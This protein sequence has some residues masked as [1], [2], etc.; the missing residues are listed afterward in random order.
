MSRDYCNAFN[1]QYY[2]L[3]THATKH[4]RRWWR[5]VAAVPAA[6]LVSGCLLALIGDFGLVQWVLNGVERRA[7]AGQS[8]RPDQWGLQVLYLTLRLGGRVVRPQAAEL[9]AYYCAGGGDT[10]RFDA[11][12]LLL[13]PE[14]QQ[15]L[16]LHKPGITFRH[17]ASAGPFYVAR[18]TDWSLYYTFDLLYIRSVPGSIVFYDNYFFQPLARRSYTR[19]S[20]GRLRC[21]LNDGLIHVAYP[22]AKPFLVY[23][24]VTIPPSQA[25]AHN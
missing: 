15:A 22:Q 1:H 4:P 5:W 10:L 16:R 19:F 7:L 2:M 21:K 18:H 23:G 13:H 17:Q 12:P 11:R 8:T 9:L 24:K 20:F 3:P 6:I 25:V 14:V